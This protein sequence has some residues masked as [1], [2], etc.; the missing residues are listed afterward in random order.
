VLGASFIA[1]EAA[2]S[3]R[4][5]GLEVAV[6]APSQRPLERVLGPDIGDFV[7]RH[8]EAHGVV[9]HL[10]HTP[11]A[12]GAS[13]VEL[14]DGRVLPADLVV[15]GIGVKPALDLAEAAGLALD[16]GVVVNEYLETSVP[17]IY[18]AGD[19]ARWPDP[20]SGPIRVE[21]WSVAQRQGQIAARNL[22][23]RR[24]RCR[25]VPFFWSR[26][27]DVTIQYVGHAETWDEASLDGDLEARSFAVTYRRAGRR[28]AVA[29]VGRRAQSLRTELE[30]EAEAD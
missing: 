23:G 3:L 26:H 2:A 16:R 4:A 12:I 8:H 25:F 30:L 7:R 27:Y 15:A 9:F 28:L 24:E 11:K 20:R 17:G 5:R 13:S 14:D 21:H 1:L 10:G 29:T 18:A 6:V 22:L 19:I